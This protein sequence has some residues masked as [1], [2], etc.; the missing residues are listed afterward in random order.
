ML[1]SHGATTGIMLPPSA[2]IVLRA[3]FFDAAG[4]ESYQELT[5]SVACFRMEISAN[6]VPIGHLDAGTCVFAEGHP[7]NCQCLIGDSDCLDGTFSCVTYEAD[8]SMAELCA[9]TGRTCGACSEGGSCSNIG[10]SNFCDCE[11]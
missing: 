8:I 10:G 2:D 3:V 4:H 7:Y 5:L 9:A 1:A 11:L 6:R